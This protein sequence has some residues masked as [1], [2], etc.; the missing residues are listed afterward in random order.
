MRT[1]DPLEKVALTILR[2][3]ALAVAATGSA[4][5]GPGVRATHAFVGVQT[6]IAVSTVLDDG[7]TLCFS[8]VY[9]NASARVNGIQE[10]CSR[11]ELLLA[12]R[13]AGDSFLTVAAHAP[14]A[15]VLFDTGMTEIPHDANGVGWYYSYGWSW[16]F[17][18]QGEP[19]TRSP[20]DTHQANAESR[21][22]WH[23]NVGSLIGGWRCGAAIGLSGDAT[24]ERLIFHRNTPSPASTGNRRRL[25]QP[26]RRRRHRRQYWSRR[27]CAE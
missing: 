16:G 26:R 27:L 10:T 21:L 3:L 2:R 8:D 17:A 24:Y 13:R 20:C 22:C 11:E 1:S 4:Q 18:P 19:I 25:P 12:C 14:R 6:N 23:T 7:W 15:D 5:V 9:A